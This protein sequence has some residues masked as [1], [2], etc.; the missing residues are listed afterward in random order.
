MSET[1]TFYIDRCL[2][3]HP[4]DFRFLV[5]RYQGALTGHLVGKL[6]NRDQAEEV[7]QE[8]LVRA[9]FKIGSLSKRDCFFA[10]LLGISDRVAKEF[11][12]K[13]QVRWQRER[14]R[15]MVQETPG[16]EMS[17]DYH[18]EEAI[19]RLPDRV[20]EVVLLRYYSQMSCKEIAER[21]TMPIGTV[22]KTLSRAYG[23][24]RRMLSDSQSQNESEVT[25]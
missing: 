2:D 5:K 6:G 21:L 18:L 7:A 4:N 16:C 17:L 20:R 12:R 13:E 8:T 24:L 10:W 11:L 1:D 25:L 19:T 3:G 23:Q 9:F 22:T 15:T 14:V